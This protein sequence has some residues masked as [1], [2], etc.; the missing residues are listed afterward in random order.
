MKLAP[1]SILAADDDPLARGFVTE[2]LLRKGYRITCAEDGRKA[3]ELVERGPFDLLIVDLKMP[4]LDGLELLRAARRLHPD[5]EVIIV[6][7]FGSV[8]SAVEAVRNGAF[9]YVTK[10]VSREKL[11]ILV[12]RALERRH[13][14]TETKRLQEQLRDQCRTPTLIGRHPKMQETLDLARLAAD[15]DATVLIRG[16]SGTGKEL[17]ARFIHACSRRRDHP[18]VKTSCAALP[19]SL[20][21]AELFGHE[22]GA[23]TNAY[24]RRI[25]RF[26]KAH[27]GTLFLDEIGDLS[28]STQIRLLGVLQ[29]RQFERLGSSEPIAIDVKVVA[30]T[31]RD[32][33][34]LIKTGHFREDLYYRLRV[35]EIVV[36]PLRQ[37]VE[38]IPLLAE[39]FLEEA[40]RRCGKPRPRL[41]PRCLDAL[42]SYRWPGNVREL[43][44][45]MERAVIVSAGERI[46]LDDLPLAPP[47]RPAAGPATP[48]EVT[49]LHEAERS[50]I[51]R[52]LCRTRWN[53][54]GAARLLGV[55]RTTLSRKIRTY[56]LE[57]T[58]QDG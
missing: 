37:R 57:Q 49:T 33:E 11:E 48:G 22:R 24:Q 39:H 23:F 30:A 20:L 31:N 26:E 2:T 5:V 50:L 43:E 55:D 40:A 10:P 7:G 56:G 8:E 28:P 16:E 17:V 21:E 54:S 53:R 36:P 18:F 14:K 25:G 1:P 45:A 52:A 4:G 58:K 51:Q 19:E 29:D 41:T 15:P 44:N 35:I 47:D 13:L 12:E 6:T 32:L 27:L 38:D 46:D 34:A 3:L 9:D 42:A